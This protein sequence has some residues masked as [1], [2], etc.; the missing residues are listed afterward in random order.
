VRRLEKQSSKPPVEV[1]L[2]AF[3]DREKVLKQLK[4]AGL[5]PREYELARLLIENPG[6]TNREAA[7]YMKIAEGTV[8]SLRS[9]IKKTLGA[10]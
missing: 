2:E 10:A 7:Q 1:E 6:M 4:D 9:R 3:V 8:K 5:P